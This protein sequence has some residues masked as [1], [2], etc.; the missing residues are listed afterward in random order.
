MKT[1]AEF[2]GE[3]QVCGRTQKLPNGKLSN[4]GYMKRWGFFEG[5]CW[6]AKHLPFEQSKAL[7]DEAIARVEKDKAEL[8]EEAE[9]RGKSVDPND[10]VCSCYVDFLGRWSGYKEI[11]G[12]IEQRVAAVIEGREIFNY[13]FVGVYANRPVEQRIDCYG[14]PYGMA[15]VIKHLNEQEAQRIRRRIEQLQSYLSWQRQRVKDW[16]KKPLKKVLSPVDG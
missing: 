2:Q 10:V 3:C 8:E 15:G 12:K 14:P 13:F 11:N 7:V 1:K 6:G 16:E 9:R 5:V 4:H